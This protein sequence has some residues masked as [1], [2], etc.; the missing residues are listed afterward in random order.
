[1]VCDIHCLIQ[2]DLAAHLDNKAKPSVVGN[3]ARV[4]KPFLNPRLPGLLL[5]V[6][7][8]ISPFFSIGDRS[9][10]HELLNEIL[11]LRNS[12]ASFKTID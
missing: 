4:E 9:T 3:H 2:P 11:N 6:N 5:E 12:K 10:F 7:P 1:M 8:D